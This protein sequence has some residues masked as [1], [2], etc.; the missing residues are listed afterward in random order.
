MLLPQ[1]WHFISLELFVIENADAA[2]RYSTV[3]VVGNLE[4]GYSHPGGTKTCDTTARRPARGGRMTL[5]P[6][7]RQTRRHDGKHSEEV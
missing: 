5:T 1:V 3:F 6:I 4:K 7:P 2:N